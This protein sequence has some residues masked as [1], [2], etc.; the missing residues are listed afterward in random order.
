MPPTGL[1]GVDVSQHQ[2]S[3]E[4]HKV[5]NAGFDF[6]IVKT[7]E[8]QDFIDPSDGPVNAPNEDR[9]RRLRARVAAIRQ[10]R[11]TLGVYHFLRP[12][13]SRTGDVEADWAVKVARQAGWG[14]PGDMR[15]FLDAIEAGELPA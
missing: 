14:K 9:L 3:V 6:A 1:T 4:W 5:A 10:Q 12:R 7:S 2:G 15:L 13:P 8:G 11:M